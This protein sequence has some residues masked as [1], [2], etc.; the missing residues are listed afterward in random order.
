[1]ELFELNRL[2]VKLEVGES[3]DM[4]S[5]DD[6]A[7]VS[8]NKREEFVF[9]LNGKVLFIQKRFR[10]FRDKLATIVE[11]RGLM[12]SDEFYSKNYNPETFQA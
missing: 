1:M 4:F 8:K 7:T 11:R 5:I 10:T 12:F 3:I 6:C 2:K 9:E